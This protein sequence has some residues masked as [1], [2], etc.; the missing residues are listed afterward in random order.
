MV[1]LIF[2]K[3]TI[4]KIDDTHPIP[5]DNIEISKKCKKSAP[6]ITQTQLTHQLCHF[7]F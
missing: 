7:K 1:I 3:L 2:F 5:V 4:D 6:V